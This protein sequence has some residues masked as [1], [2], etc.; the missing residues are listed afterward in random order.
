MDF[1]GLYASH[2][3]RISEDVFPFFELTIRYTEGDL[4][5]DHRYA[6]QH[7]M[8]RSSGDADMDIW[9]SEHKLFPWVAVAAQLKVSL[10]TVPL[11]LTR[12]SIR[13]L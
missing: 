3:P 12:S 11:T 13:I 7:V 10:D 9:A 6:I 5:E 4:Y 1:K 8:L 2:S